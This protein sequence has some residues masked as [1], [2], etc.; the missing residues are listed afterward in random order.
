MKFIAALFII[1]KTKYSIMKSYVSTLAD[2]P[3]KSDMAGR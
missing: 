1:A 2:A 3:E